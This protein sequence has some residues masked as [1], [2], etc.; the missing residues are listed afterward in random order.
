MCTLTDIFLSVVVFLRLAELNVG[1]VDIALEPNTRDSSLEY[2]N[3]TLISEIL[4]DTKFQ[5]NT[6]RVEGHSYATTV[7]L[8]KVSVQ[9][10]L[11]LPYTFSTRTASHLSSTKYSPRCIYCSNKQHSCTSPIPTYTH[12]RASTDTADVHLHAVLPWIS[13]HGCLTTVQD[14]NKGKELSQQ[15]LYVGTAATAN[16]SCEDNARECLD[17][18]CKS[19]ERR[20][21]ALWFIQVAW[22]ATLHT[23]HKARET[24][25]FG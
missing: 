11:F 17:Q 4:K 21:T 6:M 10:C 16:T 24:T 3:Y 22:T 8:S 1:E 14:C 9:F 25:L 15:E 23:L 20:Y 7:Y 13:L 12:M 18:L 2:F 19:Q 5:Y